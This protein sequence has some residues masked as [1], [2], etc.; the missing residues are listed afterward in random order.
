MRD[1]VR[2]RDKGIEGERGRQRAAEGRQRYRE[3]EEGGGG[4][5]WRRLGRGRTK[6]GYFAPSLSRSPLG[7]NFTMKLM[8]A[9]M[10][11]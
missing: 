10:K 9:E 4:A 7:E 1:R 2:E 8:N 6:I 3:R 5:G 11:I